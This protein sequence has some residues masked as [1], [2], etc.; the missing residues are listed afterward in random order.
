MQGLWHRRIQVS[1]L[2]GSLGRT[3]MHCGINRCNPSP[4]TGTHNFFLHA[5]NSLQHAFHS[6]VWRQGTVWAQ[7]WTGRTHWPHLYTRKHPSHSSVRIRG[8]RGVLLPLAG[9]KYEAREHVWAAAWGRGT[10]PTPGNERLFR[11]PFI[12]CRVWNED[13]NERRMWCGEVN[14]P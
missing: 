6:K 1:L 14:M 5:A 4:L 8:L 7:Q 2:G 13:W 3:Q 9:G 11:R 10:E 12:V